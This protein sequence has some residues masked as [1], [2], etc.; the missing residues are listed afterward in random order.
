MIDSFGLGSRPLPLA[1]LL[2]SGHG[3]IFCQD[4]GGF[5]VRLF[6]SLTGTSGLFW[7]NA[8]DSCIQPLRWAG[9]IVLFVNLVIFP[10]SSE[11][12]LRE[13]LVTSLDHIGVLSHLLGKTYTMDIT[14]EERA[15]RD[16]LNRTIRVRS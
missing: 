14:N 9:A 10:M 11:R 8:L 12:H 1:G 5:P 7:G 15:L 16:Q 4:S 13:T 6:V 2:L 3:R